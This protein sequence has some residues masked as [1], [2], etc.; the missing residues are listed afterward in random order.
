M[1]VSTEM[2]TLLNFVDHLKVQRFFFARTPQCENVCSAFL[3]DDLYILGW[4]SPGMQIV[5]AHH[6]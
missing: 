6:H 2:F 3:R 1:N 5:Q 4:R